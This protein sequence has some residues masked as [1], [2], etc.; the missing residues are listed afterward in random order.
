MSNTRIID[1]QQKQILR[2]YN[3]GYSR[4]RISR[5]LGIHR[6]TVKSY[7]ER[8]ESSDLDV[9]DLIKPETDLVGPLS[10]EAP[11]KEP[12]KRHKAFKDFVAGQ[13]NQRNKPG[14]TVDNL[15]RDYQAL[16][17]IA[18]YSKPHFYRLIRDLWKV[19]KG[20]LR[21][22]HTPRESVYLC[23]SYALTKTRR[24]YTWNHERI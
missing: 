5:E 21:L 24:V 3:L 15:Y 7:I 14:F 22:N 10:L 8:Y 18:H 17:T 19:E 11:P 13:S 1:M 12:D 16:D 9:S 2:L 23:R 4:R 6:K 20:S